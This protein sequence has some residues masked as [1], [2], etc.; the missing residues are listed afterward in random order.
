MKSFAKSILIGAGFA[1]GVFVTALTAVTISGTLNDF[2]SGDLVSAARINE[3]FASLRTAIE[4]VP[5]C[6]PFHK[7]LTRSFGSQ[8]FQADQVLQVWF[9]AEPV[10]PG[11]WN[12]GVTPGSFFIPRDGVYQ[13][14][15]MI[16]YSNVG[17]VAGYRHAYLFVN[18]ALMIQSIEYSPG[19]QIT[20][21]FSTL[22][23]LKQ[24]DEV[25]LY[26]QYDVPASN[27]DISFYAEI[28]FVRLC[29][30]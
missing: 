29:G 10:N 2:E 13:I 22:L 26:G 1:V 19:G 18:G 11:N 12:T 8:I 3:N 16:R 24:G 4:G 30:D 28:N 21:T 7:K 15:A 14:S 9:D 20:P 6:T 27:P 23:D 17:A 5:D 25:K